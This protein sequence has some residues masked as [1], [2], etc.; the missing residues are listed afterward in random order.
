MGMSPDGR[1]VGRVTSRKEEGLSADSLGD[2]FLE[3]F[4][5]GFAGAGFS[6]AGF[7]E[8]MSD[9]GAGIEG[10]SVGDFSD[11]DFLALGSSLLLI[12][13]LLLVELAS[14]FVSFS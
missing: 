14:T 3:G 10:L 4:E 6:D 1:C 7:S 2:G 8:S 5:A 12:E 11:F 9:K 13:A